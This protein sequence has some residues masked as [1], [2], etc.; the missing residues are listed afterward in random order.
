VLCSVREVHRLLI[1]L[2]D[3]LL[4]APQ[5]V[6]AALHR[7]SMELQW[8]AHECRLSLLHLRRCAPHHHQ[9]GAPIAPA[10]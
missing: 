7:Q 3:T 6:A 10:T 4:R 2:G 9:A 5:E 8:L 1:T